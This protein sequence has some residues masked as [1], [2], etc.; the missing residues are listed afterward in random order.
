MDREHKGRS[1]NHHVSDYCVLDLE[2]TGRYLLSAKIIEIGILKVRDNQVVDEFASLINPRCHIPYG[3]TAVN[4]ITDDMVGDMPCIKDLIDDIMAFIGSDV[5]VG[6][7]NAAFDM[8]LLYDNSMDICS[9][10]FTNDYIDVMHASARLVRNELLIE[11]NWKLETISRHYGLDLIDEHR[12]LKDCY[13]T[14]KCFDKIFEE[15]GD[16][17]FA[18]N[19]GAGKN[20]GKGARSK[21]KPETLALQELSSLIGGIIEDGVITDSELYY[22]SS[23]MESHTDLQGNVPFDRIF[24]ALDKVFED[25]IVTEEEL[26]ELKELFT[27]F[28]DPVKNRCCREDISS[29]C[30]KHVVLTGDF[31]YGTKSEVFSLVEKAGGVNDSGVKK[32]TDFVVVGAKGSE[33]WKTGNYGNKIEKA[34]QLQQKGSNIKIVEEGVFIPAIQR[35]IDTG[36]EYEEDEDTV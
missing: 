29:I 7:N 28:V 19:S 10:P 9:L 34:M 12:A 11:D 22:L 4:H 13:L 27:D 20:K 26:A 21:F 33:A 14:K 1:V 30:G 17:A 23:W 18:G 16:A 36:E 3:T 5:I 8:N 32:T 25:G 6:Y 31:D 35:I 15:F 2:T 24:S